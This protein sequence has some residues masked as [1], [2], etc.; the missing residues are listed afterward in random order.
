MRWLLIHCFQY[1]TVQLKFEK[2]LEAEKS[3]N[4]ERNPRSKDVHQQQTQLVYAIKSSMIQRSNL[5]HIEEGGG[6]G[7]FYHH[8]AIPAAL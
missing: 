3:E 1:S 6:V 8:S 4:L 5:G 2:T 7:G